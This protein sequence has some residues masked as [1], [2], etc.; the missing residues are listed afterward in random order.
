MTRGAQYTFQNVFSGQ[1]IYESWTLSFYNVFYTVLPPLA[2][3]ILDQFISARLLDRYPQLYMMG[4]NNYFFRLKVFA[5]W[6]ANAFYH[7]L[8]LYAA[9]QLIWYGDL[10]QGDGKTAGHWVWGTALYGAVLLTVLGKAALVT[11]NWTKYH[12]LA[13]PG[14]MAV[15]YVFIA[16]Y[17]SLGPMAG[18]STEYRGVV[19]RL[20]T[21]PIFWLQTMTLAMLCLLRDFA[22]KYAKRMYW[23]QTY[24]HIQEIQKYNIQDYRPRMEQFQKAIRKV[25]QVQRMRK[26][27][28]YAFSQADESQTRVL[29]AYDTTK[30]RGRYGEMASSRPTGGTK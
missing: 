16:A 6:I 20:Y 29:Q 26:Q 9:T 12:V 18:L 14:S 2:L 15:W 1:V 7:S 28:G 10:I 21:S 17:G 19:P 22:W 23:P 3:G 27:R 8:V 11:S 25:R 13:I 24:H 5:E 30:H 4:Q